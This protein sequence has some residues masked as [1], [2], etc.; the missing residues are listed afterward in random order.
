M[1]T[2]VNKMYVLESNYTCDWSDSS[3]VKSSGCSTS[4]WVAASSP[5]TYSHLKFQLQRIQ[6]PLL[7][8]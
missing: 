3:M 8:L 7:S 4:V 2:S 6:C 1:R 5:V